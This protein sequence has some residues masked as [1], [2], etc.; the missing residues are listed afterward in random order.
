M[1][2]DKFPKSVEV[3]SNDHLN[4]MLNYLVLKKPS[5]LRRIKSKLRGEKASWKLQSSRSWANLLMLRWG[6]PNASDIIRTLASLNEA[7]DEDS[8]IM[9]YLE[10]D[11]WKDADSAQSTHSFVWNRNDFHVMWGVNDAVIGINTANVSSM[12][13]EWCHDELI[14]ASAEYIKTQKDLETQKMFIEQLTNDKR[15]EV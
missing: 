13:S 3:F 8:A 12:L 14:D 9:V 10:K 2:I 1:K 6:K 4:V 11:P 7:K 5:L 15:S